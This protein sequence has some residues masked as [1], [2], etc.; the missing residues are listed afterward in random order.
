MRIPLLHSQPREE[1]RREDSGELLG[2]LT[3]DLSGNRADRSRIRAR[4]T[5][6]IMTLHMTNTFIIATYGSHSVYSKRLHCV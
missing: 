1:Q 5:Y 4:C 2:E 3:M 6:Q